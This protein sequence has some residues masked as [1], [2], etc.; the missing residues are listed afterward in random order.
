MTPRPRIRRHDSGHAVGYRRVSTEEQSQ[1]GLGL[2]GQ[3]A[4]ITAAAHRHGL[5]VRAIYT[6]A[7]ISGAAAIDKRP[8]L[9]AAL[10]ALRRGDVL[11][12]AK[13]DRLA[14]DMINAA[15]IEATARRKGARIVSAA[16]EGTDSDDPSDQLQ[17]MMIDAFATYERLVIR[18]R[19]RAAL[20]AKSARGERVSGESPFGYRFTSDNRLEPQP[21]ELAIVAVMRDC[22]EAGFS[23]R[24]TTRELNRLGYLTRSGQPWRWEYVRNVVTWFEQHGYPTQDT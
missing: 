1:S 23:Y 3:T 9:L 4:A 19:T 8:E 20:R 10:A 14:R 2:D 22:H 21:S 24:G 17:R 16:G 18:A 6:D 13:R 15:L 7:G 12:I 5:T 11:L